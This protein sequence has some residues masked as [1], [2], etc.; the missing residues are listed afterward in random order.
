MD[1]CLLQPVVGGL[2]GPHAGARRPQGAGQELQPLLLW[3]LQSGKRV[4][5]EV[6]GGG[7]G[8]RCWEDIFQQEA[9][10]WTARMTCA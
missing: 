3:E 4:A 6:L 8:R 1:L 7:A 5:S 2:S 9:P 10:P